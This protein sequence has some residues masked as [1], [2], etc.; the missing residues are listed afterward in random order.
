M[1][2]RVKFYDIDVIEKCLYLDFSDEL[3]KK[4]LLFDGLLLN[5]LHCQQK[6]YLLVS[7]LIKMYLAVYTLLNLPSPISLSN[8]KSETTGDLLW[9]SVVFV[10]SVYLNSFRLI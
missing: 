2:D 3:L 5:D 10:D 1:K 6:T 8:R 9:V 4:G 7:E